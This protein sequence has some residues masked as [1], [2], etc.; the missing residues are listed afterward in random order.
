MFIEFITNGSV[1]NQGWAINYSA[2]TAPPVPCNGTTTLT[3]NSG[4]FSDGSGSANYINNTNCSWLILPTNGQNIV[5]S[6]TSFDTEN[7]F[8]FVTIFDGP[9]VTS[10]VLGNYSGS[11]IPASVTSTGPSMFV[12][13]TS[14]AT[15]VSQGWDAS[16]TTTTTGSTGCSGLTTLTA[17]TGTV[18]DGSGTA[19]YSNNLS[20]TWL[21]QPA[22]ATSITANFN[23]L[24]TEVNNDQVIIYDGPNNASPVLGTYSG[25]TTPAGTIISTTG[26]MFIEFVTNASVVDQGWEIAWTAATPPGGPCSGITNLTSNNG[27]FSDG[28]GTNNYADNSNCEWLIQPANGQPITL[29]F[30]AFDIEIGFDLV[31]VYDGNSTASPF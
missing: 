16:Y 11:G 7:N 14:D 26:A 1:V 22:G 8:D 24:L 5:L 9:N 6:F 10:P 15:I 12:Q 31:S 4:T 28:S 17:P 13:F 27:S 2:T 3:A 19:N 21:I 25:T 29:N 20:C 18:S 23:S 30:T